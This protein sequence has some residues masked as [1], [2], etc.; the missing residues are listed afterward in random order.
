MVDLQCVLSNFSLL[1]ILFV[2]EGKSLAE[3]DVFL[4]IFILKIFRNLLT[5]N[6]KGESYLDTILKGKLKFSFFHQKLNYWA[7][8]ELFYTA[9]CSLKQ[10]KRKIPSSFSTPI[11]KVII[12]ELKSIE[13]KIYLNSAP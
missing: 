3:H 8:I 11:C 7:C 4:K 10:P 1:S 12:E 2:E 13:K 9:F 5:I 6:I